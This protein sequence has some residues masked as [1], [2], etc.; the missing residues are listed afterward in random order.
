LKWCWILSMAFSVSIEMIKWFLSLLLL[1][2]HITFIDLHMLDH[3]ASLGWIQ[4]SH[5]EWSVW[6]VVG[7][8]LSLFYWGLLHWCSLRRLAYSSPLQM[9]LWF[10]DECNTAS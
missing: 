10:W 5:G 9:S 4:L 3:P 7:F 1:M 8:S 6:Y 2:C